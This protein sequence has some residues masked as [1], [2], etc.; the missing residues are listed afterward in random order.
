MFVPPAAVLQQIWGRLDAGVAYVG[1]PILLATD[2]DPPVFAPKVCAN[3][4]TSRAA[5]VVT[6]VIFTQHLIDVLVSP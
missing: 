2:Q 4:V 6:A 3:G 1:T 5:R